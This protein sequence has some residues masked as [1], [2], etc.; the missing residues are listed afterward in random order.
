MKVKFL[1]KIFPIV[2]ED[3]E[4]HRLHVMSQWLIM[5]IAYLMIYVLFV[6]G[7]YYYISNVWRYYGFYWYPDSSRFLESIVAILLVVFFLPK[8]YKKPSDILLHTQFFFPILPMLVLYGAMDLSRFFT[9]YIVAL[10]IAIIILSR[11]RL[12]NSAT[13]FSVSYGFLQQISLAWVIATILLIVAFG[14]MAYFNFDLSLVYETRRAAG[15]SRPG[16]LSYIIP[17]TTKVVLPFSLILAIVNRRWW[18]VLSLLFSSIMLFGLCNHK[19]VFFYPWVVM[20]LF[21]LIHKKNVIGKLLLYFI[22][23]LLFIQGMH[24][25]LGGI[26]EVLVSW[27]M[28]R[29]FFVPALINYQYYDFFSQSPQLL[30][31]NSS[32]T[33]GMLQQPYS[34]SG[35]FTMGYYYYGNFDCSANTGWIGSGFM[36]AGYWGMALYAGLISLLLGIT[37]ALAQNRNKNIVTAIIVIPF[38]AM[39]S[40]SDLPTALLTHGILVA[41]ILLVLLP[42]KRVLFRNEGCLN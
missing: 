9:F 24:L 35:P 25:L 10:F 38:F 22:G 15:A 11:I 41:L 28:R 23:M 21:H 4:D 42:T 37:D 5:M 31:S 18:C 39:F 36:Q 29:V 12:F 3:R 33:L 40:G 32:F 14:G 6:Y 7:Y 27:F 34:L 20:F 8:S 1:D 26:A 19:S 13:G 16:L 17:V 2:I 30:W